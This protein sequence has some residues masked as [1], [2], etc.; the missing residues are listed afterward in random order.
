M[1]DALLSTLSALVSGGTLLAEAAGHR[2]LPM[3]PVAFGVAFF[4]ILA[5]AL[6]IVTRLKIDR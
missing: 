5:L 6:W 3:S 1:V 4:G 2:E